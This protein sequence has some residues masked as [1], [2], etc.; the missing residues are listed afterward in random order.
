M[1]YTDPNTNTVP[2]GE[3]GTG[4]AYLLPQSQAIN[5]AYNYIDQQQADK[6]KANQLK[7]QQAKALADAW[8]DNQLKIKGGTLFQPEINAR[9]QKIMAQGLALQKAGVNPNL[10]SNDPN[11]QKMVD[12]YQSQ[13]ASLLSDT[14]AR[15]QIVK[16]AGDN[17]KLIQAQP[18]GYYD[19]QSVQAYHD[20]ISGKVPLSQITGNGLQMPE[21]KKAFD[22]NPLI[23]KIPGVPI[24]TTGTN[25]VTGVKTRLVLPNEQAHMALA[26]S[27]VANT[28]EVQADIAN[29]AGMPYNSI[30][31]ETDPNVLAKQLDDHYRSLPN[32][33]SLAAQ[34]VKTFGQYGTQN[35]AGVPDQSTNPNDPSNAQY[36]NL[37]GQQAQQMARA[38]KV[39][40]DYISN[41]KNT[42]DNK[43]HQTD[44][45]SWDFAYQNEQD[46]RAR[47][48]MDLQKFSKWKEDQQDEAGTFSLG[49][50]GSYVPV[51]KTN[52]KDG[53][54]G[55]STVE[56]EQG[57]SL[58]GV[59]LPQVKTV[60]RPSLVT[61]MKTGKTVKNTQPMEVAVSQ[62]QM[63]PVFQNLSDNDPR[64]GSE[65]SA[66]QLK[67]I[68]A[69]KHNFAGLNNITFQPFAYGIKSEHDGNNVHTVNTPV[70]FS[71]DA[72]KGSNV[73]K[74]NTTNFDNA[75]DGLKALQ[76]N[77]K[78]QQLSPEEK[79]DFITKKYNIK[80]D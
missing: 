61:D 67:Q 46:R 48:G 80:L 1:A 25:P 45:K 64:N 56:P 8:K 11:T 78:F 62:I 65:V 51:I 6:E 40:S 28:P 54:Q 16:Q 24:E 19:P 42:L 7:I 38:A 73:K 12:D 26:N 57:A 52:Q 53:Q 71:F 14:E 74:I 68:V 69:G 35:S 4:A 15:D 70:K 49:N 3:A 13:K 41:I 5:Q 60:V 47:L 77:P 39:K 55:Q 36:S 32:I 59:N 2:L 43:V 37:I 79:L 75:V 21:L 72:L 63:V 58:F 17:E 29:K 34:G 33:P 27:L 31:T 44:D 18:A 30:G 10:I 76:A 50:Q 23:D 20:Y 66:R 9:A 22:L